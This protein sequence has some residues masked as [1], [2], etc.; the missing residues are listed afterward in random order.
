MEEFTEM[1]RTRLPSSSSALHQIYS[2][3]LLQA[4]QLIRRRRLE[5]WRW[6]VGEGGA[7]PGTLKNCYFMCSVGNLSSKKWGKVITSN[8]YIWRY[9]QTI[10]NL[11]TLMMQVCCW[12]LVALQG[13]FAICGSLIIAL[14]GLRWGQ[15]AK[16]FFLPHFAKKSGAKKTRNIILFTVFPLKKSCQGPFPPCGIITKLRSSTWPRMLWYHQPL[17]KVSV[18]RALRTGDAAKRWHAM[19]WTWYVGWYLKEI[20]GWSPLSR[21]PP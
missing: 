9:G 18:Q 14:H 10:K 4:Q 7:G 17:L 19:W 12:T 15:P 11:N 21:Y 1:L 13:N 3:Q 8:F 16:F 5:Q 6:R 2:R 20:F